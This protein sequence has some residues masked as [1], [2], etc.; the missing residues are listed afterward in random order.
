MYG[1][2][3]IFIHRA[4]QIGIDLIC[5]ERNH[6]GCCLC[7]CHQ[8][9]IKGHIGI[10]LILFH[11]LCPETLT[12]AA[13]V[14]VTHIIYEALQSLC[15]FRDPVI[16]K[17]LIHALHHGIHLRQE[18]L[19]HNGKLLIIQAVFCSIELIDICIK[20]KEGIGIPK[21][22]HEFSLSLYNSL[23]VETVGQPGCGIA[24][25]IPADRICAIFLQSIKR[26]YRISLGLT[27]LLSVLIL[28]VTQHDNILVRRFSKEK[29]GLCHQRIEPASGLINSLGNKLSRELLLKKF[30]IFKRIM[31]LC[32]RHCTGI[33]PAVNYLRHSLHLAAAFRTLADN[34]INVRSVKLNTFGSFVS[35]LLEKILSGTDR[36]LVAAFLAL[37]DIQRCAPVTVSGDTPVLHILKPVAKTSL[38]DGFRNPVYGIVV[39]DQLILYLCHLDKPRFSCVIDQGC[40]TSPAMRIIMLKF[41]SGKEKASAFKILQHLRVSLLHEETCKRCILCQ[42]TLSIYKLNERQTIFL[43]NASIILTKSRCDMNDTG[44]I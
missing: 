42:V 41:R 20:N 14:P 19:V 9:L 39:C 16:A 33:K 40:I 13:N 37:P 24:V 10:D 27:H 36:I 11:A 38:T 2:R 23:P 4:H 43:A 28:H 34:V 35:A 6:G 22:S 25:E 12:A 3:C 18:P 7:S 5:H 17:I 32:K 8:C 29:S 30:L 26:I 15:C 44:T 31:M 21:G 1:F